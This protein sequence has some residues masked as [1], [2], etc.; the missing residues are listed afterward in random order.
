M[1]LAKEELTM[2]HRS[3]AF[4]RITLEGRAMGRANAHRQG[5]PSR[6]GKISPPCRCEDALIER[7]IRSNRLGAF[8]RLFSSQRVL[9]SAYRV[10]DFACGLVR[11]S[12]A[13][14][15]GITR[16]FACNFLHLTLWPAR[17]IP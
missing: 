3:H 4:D 10:P 8:A 2:T 15:L 9:K 7:H 16:H 5:A 1:I 11:L 13:F 14:E 17:L 6:R 12:L